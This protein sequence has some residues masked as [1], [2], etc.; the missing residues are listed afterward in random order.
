MNE[1]MTEGKI[2]EQWST[3]GSKMLYISGK[4]FFLIRNAISKQALQRLTVIV[5]IQQIGIGFISVT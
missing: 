3:I 1:Q 5:H 4:I 2:S